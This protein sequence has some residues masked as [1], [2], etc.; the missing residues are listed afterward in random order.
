MHKPVPQLTVAN[1]EGNCSA[2]QT[3]G[4]DQ[5]LQA[6]LE[7]RKALHG[8]LLALPSLFLTKL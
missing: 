7:Q 8:D 5:V 6:Q 4:E 2:P 3:E 1:T